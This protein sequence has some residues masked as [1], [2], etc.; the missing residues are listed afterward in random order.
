MDYLSVLLGIIA[1]IQ[2]WQERSQRGE[3]TE[4]R[5]EFF[6]SLCKLDS[7]LRV[8]KS[9]H[10]VLEDFIAET[11]DHI[12][13]IQK[14]TSSRAAVKR[15]ANYYLNFATKAIDK[16]PL[17]VPVLSGA[18]ERRLREL[19]ADRTRDWTRKIYTFFPKVEHHISNF[20]ASQTTLLTL[21]N[22]GR[23]TDTDFRK[24][25]TNQQYHVKEL[26]RYADKCIL[27]SAHLTAY[28]HEEALR[29][30]A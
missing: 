21:A 26:L 22:E 5:K 18:V 20:R 25:C 1:I 2:G 23:V 27:Y 3:I 6:D 4:C 17:E 24:E 12:T 16:L 7:V 9:V 19:P 13:K 14:E 8:S 29:N 28:L 30:T 11:S 10:D 15:S